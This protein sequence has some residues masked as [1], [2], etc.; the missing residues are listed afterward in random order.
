MDKEI[1]KDVKVLW[2]YLCL[3]E[4]DK[5][6]ECIIGLGSILRIV[7]EKCA[8]LYHEGY[9]DY[10]IFSGNCGKGTE[11]VIE[12]TEAEIFKDCAVALEIPENKIMTENMAT[13]TY[14]N[15]KYIKNVLASNHLN[16]QSF[17]IVGKPYQ[18]R[19]ARAIASVELA[20]KTFSISTFQMDLDDFLSYVEKNK[21][22]TTTDVINELVAE[23]NINLLAPSYGLQEQEEIPASV[24]DSY[25]Q[26]IKK[27]Y[28]RYLINDEIIEKV[29]QHWSEQRLK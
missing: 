12:R 20:D 24:L 17:L 14:E 27:G 11:G 6:A 10:L 3:H 9:G 22:M 13:N 4:E 29:I 28:C 8:Q 7:P 25:N 1:R 16:P 19:R 26:L 5:K 21:L 18:E 23:I 15:F 2:D